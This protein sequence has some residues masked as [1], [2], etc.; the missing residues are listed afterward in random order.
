MLEILR[1]KFSIVS[2]ENTTTWMAWRMECRMISFTINR[3]CLVTK[4]CLTLCDPVD[5]NARLLGIL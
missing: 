2:Q 5:C 4:S 3:C 1:S